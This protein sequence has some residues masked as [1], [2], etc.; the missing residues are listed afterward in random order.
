MR[1]DEKKSIKLKVPWFIPG[2]II[3]AAIYTFLPE[4][5]PFVAD[6]GKFLKSVSKNL[7]VLILFFIGANLSKDKLRELGFKPVIH[8]I[9]LW[10]I[11]S[12]VW[13]AAIVTG[14]VK[15]AK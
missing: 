4:H 13:C 6:V 5:L 9:I 11:L 2:F 15:C 7:M 12:S 8:G 14:V 1:F 3:A 10:L